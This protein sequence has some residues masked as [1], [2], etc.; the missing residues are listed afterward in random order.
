MLLVIF[1]DISSGRLA[2]HKT[3]D[4]KANVLIPNLICSGTA[5]RRRSRKQIGGQGN[6]IALQTNV[7]T[8]LQIGKLMLSKTPAILHWY[9]FQ[10]KIPKMHEGLRRELPYRDEK[11]ER[12]K[13]RKGVSNSE[14]M[15][16]ATLQ[17]HR[18]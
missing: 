5:W 1:D 12:M 6:A 18:E 7:A 13:R 14:H 15:E 3:L 17:L 10:H 4:P 2:G 8:L 9:C 11:K 16:S